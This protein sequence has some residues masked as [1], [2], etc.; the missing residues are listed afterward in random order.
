MQQKAPTLPQK[1]PLASNISI[2]HSSIKL[3]RP[4][5]GR[6]PTSRHANLLNRRCHSSQL[7]GLAASERIHRRL[8]N[9]HSTGRSVDGEHVDGLALIRQSEALPAS[10][11]VISRDRA[12]AAY[13][14]EGGD[15]AESFPAVSMRRQVSIL[16][17]G[18]AFWG[19]QD[20]LGRETHSPCLEA[21]STVGASYA[22]Q[23]AAF[24][25]VGGV[26]ADAHGLS[27][28]E[29]GSAEECEGAE[30]LHGWVLC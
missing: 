5:F 4:P 23:A 6:Q 22:V 12:R 3:N 11:G 7:H 30:E 2:K 14:R 19:F 15:L 17:A 1:M 18:V 29:G 21:V 16:R 27:G 13:I 25:V 20:R 9:V 10:I 28:C 8:S 24:R 26:I